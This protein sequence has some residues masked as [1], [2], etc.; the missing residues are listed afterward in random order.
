MN[1]AREKKVF[2]L[3]AASI[4]SVQTAIT[5]AVVIDND[6]HIILLKHISK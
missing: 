4:I 3:L 6:I 5:L 2:D 1:P